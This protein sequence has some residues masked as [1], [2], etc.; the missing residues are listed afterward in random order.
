MGWGAAPTLNHSLYGGGF[1]VNCGVAA[2]KV[3]KASGQSENISCTRH[4]LDIL[5][6]ALTDAWKNGTALPSKKN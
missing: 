2:I 1:Y 6:D 3:T 5:Y 4:E